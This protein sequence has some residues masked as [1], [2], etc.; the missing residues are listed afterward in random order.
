MTRSVRKEVMRKVL[1]ASVPAAVVLAA[2]L[3]PAE[4]FAAPETY[5]IDPAHS[6]VAF[7]IRHLF[8]RVPGRFTKFEGIV[9]LD[10]ADLS[11]SG[12]SVTIEAASIDTDEAK[13]DE[14]LRSDA[15]FDVGKHPTISF[16]S[17]GVKVVSKDKLQV[18]GNLTIRGTTKPVTLDVDLLGTGPGF[19][20]GYRA[21]F[22]GRTR[23]NRQDYGVSWNKA[24]EG[25]GTILGDDVDITLNVEAE[26][27]AQAPGGEK[28]PAPP[29]EPKKTPAAP[30]PSGN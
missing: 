28:K 14:H 10:Q 8:S 4:G 5:T 29:V 30:A 25:G 15:F 3:T 22:E 19:G 6:A 11:R 7:K 26:R 23:I 1:A 27:K 13:R 20:G 2:F 12:V 16:Q 9:T 18:S 21:G 17:T 24:L